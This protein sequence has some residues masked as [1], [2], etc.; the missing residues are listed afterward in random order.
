MLCFVLFFYLVHSKLEFGDDPYKILKIPRSS[1]KSEIKS[2]Y[3]KLTYQL[4][5]DT[6]K[7][8]GSVEKWITVND[9]YELLSDPDRKARFDRYGTFEDDESLNHERGDLSFR[10]FSKDK[11]PVLV[12]NITYI[13]SSN[14]SAFVKKHSDNIILISNSIL[15]DE[16]D[17]Y[18]KI[19]DEFKN[20]HGKVIGC[21]IVDVS[22]NSEFAKSLAITG[23]PVFIYTNSNGNISEIVKLGG[24]VN[25]ID[26]IVEFLTSRWPKK[27][28]TLTSLK[29]MQK[30]LNNDPN[31]VHIIQI[32]RNGKPTILFQRIASAF[33]SDY[34]FA[35][36]KDNSLET[37]QYLNV[38][39]YPQV[40]I[41]R[42]P[43]II[44]HKVGIM[45]ELHKEIVNWGTPTLFHVDRYSFLRACPE[46]C[47]LRCG[48]PNENN[49][50]H[51]SLINRTTGYLDIGSE[52]ARKLNMT[53]GDWI[54]MFTE[55][56]RFAKIEK[57]ID[58]YATLRGF[59]D[60][61]HQKKVTVKE[62][63]PKFEFEFT[64]SAFIDEFIRFIKYIYM[65]IGPSKYY[66][67]SAIFFIAIEIYN[68]RKAKPVKVQIE[69][70]TVKSKGRNKL[71]K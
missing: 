2:A 14:F 61:Y 41:Y 8:E 19:F 50:K 35:V 70:Q 20:R 38:S 51:L 36:L 42:N 7:E 17:E 30:F 63:P 62:L 18:T 29:Q 3:R 37:S 59:W 34:M 71:R 40:L 15:C 33:R 12:H 69:K 22:V 47:F 11:E 1:T 24:K 31:V 66:I 49:A 25:S 23:Y 10:Y 46:M 52:A 55:I 13:D 9:A 58:D 57:R 64:L 54:A 48:M 68:R 16:C 6:S 67:L 65:F 56:G 39:H 5:P 27:I 4:H 26:D 43:N 45:K 44:P 60:D 28:E 32:I 21:G 53:E